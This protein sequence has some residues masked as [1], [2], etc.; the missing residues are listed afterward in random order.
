MPKLTAPLLSMGA[1]GQLGKTLVFSTWKGVPYARQ[2]VIPANPKSTK[3][4]ANRSIWQMLN[5]AWLYAPTAVQAPFN[6]FASGKPLTGRNKFFSENQSLLAVQPTPSDITDFVMSPGSGGGLPSSSLVV[7]PG[8]L[9]LALAATAPD[10]P[11]GWSLVAAHAAAIVNQ[12]PT[13]PFSGEWF[14]ATNAVAPYTCTITGLTASVEYAVGYWL[15]WTKPDGSTAY[16]ISLV[17]VGTPTA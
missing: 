15:E 16:S 13:D 14:Y 1:R 9:E 10:V 11:S 3:Q 4:T 8:S 7:T 12:D 5:T 17:D 6:A 2:H